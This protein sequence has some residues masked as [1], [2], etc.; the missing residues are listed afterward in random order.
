MR[1]YG[2]S[3][4][5]LSIASFDKLRTP[6]SAALGVAGEEVTMVRIRFALRLGSTTLTT[7]RSG[8]HIRRFA[9]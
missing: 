8:F 6:L 7:S 3:A 1:D 9:W 4:F 5:C 2:A